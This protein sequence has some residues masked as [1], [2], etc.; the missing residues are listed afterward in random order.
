MFPYKIL[1]VDD[2]HDSIEIIEYFIRNLPDFEIIG[3]CIDGEE[4]VEQIILKKPDLVLTDINMPKKNGIDAIKECLSFNHDLKFIFF[5]GYDEY[6]L[7]AFRL[8]AV[9]Y[10]V[11]PIE[12]ERLYQ[13]LDKARDLLRYE[14]EKD[15]P[16]RPA[17]TILNLTLK[18]QKGT[19]YIPLKD[20]YFIEKIEKK[21]LVYTKEEIYETNE[22]ISKLLE[23]LDDTFFH[24]HRSYIINLKK[25]SHIMPRNE[26][27]IVHFAN[28]S[29]QAI[30]SKLKINDVKEKISRLLR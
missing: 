6:A 29:N 17:D 18:D 11:K 3:V 21:C 14:R 24:S 15:N 1:L 4:L 27:Y 2:N 13:A 30:I 19:R 9:D 5:T 28:Y 22:T 26:S 7:E 10:L 8:S 12:K 23:R 16:M 25:I 20:I